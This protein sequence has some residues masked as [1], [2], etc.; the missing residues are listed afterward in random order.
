MQG[1]G[2]EALRSAFLELGVAAEALTGDPCSWP[3][4]G[5]DESDSGILL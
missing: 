2:P 5:C 4:A 1:T 3:G